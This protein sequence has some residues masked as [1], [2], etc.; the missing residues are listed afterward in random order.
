MNATQPGS[1]VAST[2]AA[3][4]HANTT[5]R[6]M[7]LM[8]D[9]QNGYYWIEDG[10]CRDKPGD[11]VVA[12][13]EPQAVPPVGAPALRPHD[14]AEFRERTSTGVRMIPST[15]DAKSLRPVVYVAGPLSHGDLRE[16]IRRGCEAGIALMKAGLSPI[17]PHDTCFWGMTWLGDGC[18][19]ELTPAGTTVDDWYGMDLPIVRKADAVLRLPGISRGADLETAMARECGI[20]VFG[21]VEEVVAWASL[22]KG[23]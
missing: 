17:V 2:S 22:P 16:N 19:P 9:G 5:Q 3:Q 10:E 7:T 14:D 8:A 12:R 21:S 4:S 15:R 6:P 11:T 1:L 20:P 23:K 18:L 13:L